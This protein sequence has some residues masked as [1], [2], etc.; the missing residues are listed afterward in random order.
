MNHKSHK[1]FL[2][3]FVL[4]CSVFAQAQI[5]EFIP[6]NQLQTKTPKETDLKAQPVPDV[7]QVEKKVKNSTPTP[8]ASSNIL[9]VIVSNGYKP[10]GQ[11]RGVKVAHRAP[12]KFTSSGAEIWVNTTSVSREDLYPNY[13]LSALDPTS[14]HLL[15]SLLPGRYDFS[16]GGSYSNGNYYGLNYCAFPAFNLYYNNLFTI[17]TDPFPLKNVTA[18]SI[19]TFLLGSIETASAADGSIYG[20]FYNSNRSGLEIG[21]A[22]FPNLTRTTI[23]SA[24]HQYVAMGITHDNVLYGI[25]IDGNLY[26]ISLTDGSDQLVGP[27]G[28]AV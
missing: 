17:P 21:K 10:G 8:V 16:E 13:A 6:L 15:H 3:A 19:S 22:D 18:R 25:A 28:V 23:G 27:T 11:S 2:L 9:N 7:G 14:P 26:K 4:S 12:G 5:Q 24:R 1:F 20:E